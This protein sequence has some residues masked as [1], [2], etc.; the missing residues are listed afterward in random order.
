MTSGG[1]A[2][3]WEGADRSPRQCRTRPTGGFDPGGRSCAT[4]AGSTLRTLAVRSWGEDGAPALVCLHGVTSWGGHFETLAERLAPGHRLIAPDLLGHGDSPRE[5]PWRIGEHLESLEATLGTVPRA[6][7]GH[8]FG[9]RLA[10]EYA[11]AHPEAVARLVLLDPAILLAPHVALWAAE[12]A[13]PERRYASFDEAIGRRYEESQLHHAPRWLVESELR[14][15]LVEDA[16]GWRYRYTQAA[17]VA[18]HGEMATDPPPFEAVRVPTLL[19]L[20]AQSY[21]PYDHLLAAH[22]TA[23]G[24]LLEVVTVPGG[25]TVLWDALDETAAA[26]AAFLA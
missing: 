23:L 9:G 21:L 17:V 25:H 19:V 3:P 14:G 15:H 8:S 12:N 6:W 13:R 1:R 2:P 10:F 11:A 16:D 4:T 24:D 18:A 20:G 5:P 7:L 26:I 22:R